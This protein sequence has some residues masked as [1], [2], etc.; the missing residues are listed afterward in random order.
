MFLTYC[1]F[2][3]FIAVYCPTDVEERANSISFHELTETMFA[4]VV[5]VVRT[6]CKW[7]WQL[8]AATVRP[9]HGPLDSLSRG[10]WPTDVDSGAASEASCT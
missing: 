2:I 9:T 8:Q 4:Y 10:P 3:S 1:L 5:P 6:S 7:P